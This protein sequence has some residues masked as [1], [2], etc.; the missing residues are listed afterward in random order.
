MNNLVAWAERKIQKTWDGHRWDVETVVDRIAN[1]M[2]FVNWVRCNVEM[3]FWTNDID[4]L[5]VSYDLADKWNILETKYS[6]VPLPDVIFSQDEHCL[7]V[8]RAL[9]KDGANECT[10]L[11]EWSNLLENLVLGVRWRANDHDISI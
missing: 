1:V 6:K 2:N 7:E 11:E 5:T 10:L 9:S 4:I 8:K 3:L